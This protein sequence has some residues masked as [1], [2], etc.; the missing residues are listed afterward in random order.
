MAT[1]ARI[2]ESNDIKAAVVAVAEAIREL[3]GV[4]LN[5]DYMPD[6]YGHPYFKWMAEFKWF[7]IDRLTEDARRDLCG[8]PEEEASW[9]IV[10]RYLADYTRDTKIEDSNGR[11]LSSPFFDASLFDL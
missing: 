6:P 11:I 10:F 3:T 1:D 9:K 5:T 8:I 4:T 2:T 7:D